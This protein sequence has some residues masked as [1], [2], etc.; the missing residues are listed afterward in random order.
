VDGLLAYLMDKPVYPAHVPY[1]TL[2]KPQSKEWVKSH[3]HAFGSYD[4]QTVLRAP[5][6]ARLLSD[7]KV[8]SLLAGYFGCLPTVASINLFWS[9]TSAD[10]KAK[11]PQ[12]YH[13]DVD[14]YKTS[15]MF[16]NL[17]DTDRND[18]AHEY[19]EHTQS[20]RELARV[21]DDSKND[22]YPSSL[23]HLGR[24]FKP[25]D[26][27]GLPLNGY[28][29]DE[30]Y[31]HFFKDQSV[32][33]H[34][35]RGQVLITDNYGIHRGI[36]PRSRDRLILWVSFALTATHTRSAAVKYQKRVAYKDVA[37]AV[38]DNAVNRYVLRNVINFS[39]GT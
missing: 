30:L 17:T 10:E 22:S 2:Q 5:H 4:L 1:F 11:G 25:E 15:T 35:Q 9:F 32:Q 12:R 36:P 13:R 7:T 31:K 8:I 14:D 24:R 29:F 38:E 33:L 21:F 6:V 23:N 26:F 28:S 18:G 3:G 19:L 34:G 39:Q 37:D 27:F 16:I 20:I